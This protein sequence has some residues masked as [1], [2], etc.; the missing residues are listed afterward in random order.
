M[1]TDYPHVI[2]ALFIFLII[3]AGLGW[4]PDFIARERR[5]KRRERDRKEAP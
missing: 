4:I 5:Q 2:G 3:S 1:T